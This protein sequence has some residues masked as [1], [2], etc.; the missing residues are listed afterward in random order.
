RG[1]RADRRPVRERVDVRPALLLQHVRIPIC[2]VADGGYGALREGPERGQGGRRQLQEPA[3]G[4]RLGLSL[5][6]AQGSG[7]RPR[8]TRTLSRG[9]AQDER[10]HGRDG[11]VTG[12]TRPRITPGEAYR[13]GLAERISTGQPLPAV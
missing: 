6:P 8:D 7:R 9:G 12:G 13:A 5:Q 11:A 10:D 4:R 2:D 1:R 3:A